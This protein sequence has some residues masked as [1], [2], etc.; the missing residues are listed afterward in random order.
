MSV[1]TMKHKKKVYPQ[2]E[3]NPVLCLFL[4]LA[5][6]S[7]ACPTEN[8]NKKNPIDDKENPVELPV[9]ALH[10]VV[11]DLNNNPLEG[12]RVSTGSWSATT[13]N[14][15][16]F[17]FETAGIVNNRAVIKFEKSG[18]FTIT[19]SGTK[20]DEIFIRAKLHRKGNSDISVQTTFDAK[21][22][23]ILKI[24]SPSMNNA[25]EVDLSAL[26]LARADGSDYEGD[27]TADMLYLDP[28]NENFAELMP[29]GDLAAT[30]TD[31]S[32][33]QLIS[34]GMTDVNFADEDGNP[35]QL[36]NGSPAKT[37]FPI[38]EGMEDNPP[39]TIPLWSFDEQQGIWVEEGVATLVPLTDG[40]YVYE[41][42]TTH[43]S[44]K[45]LDV[46]A[47]R[48]TLRGRVTDC[49]G[50]PA[51]YVSIKLG[52]V[53]VMAGRNGDYVAYVPD[54][55]SL[56]AT[57]SA[58]GG[59][60]SHNIPGQSGGSEYKQ[61]FSVPCGNG[62]PG[63]G[64]PGTLSDTDK[65]SVKYRLGHGSPETIILTFAENGQRTRWD[66]YNEEENTHTVIIGNQ[67]K[68]TCSVYDGYQW[69]TEAYNSM[70]SGCYGMSSALMAVVKSGRY[71]AVLKKSPQTVTIA[72]KSC[73]IYMFD[74]QDSCSHEITVWNG[75]MMSQESSCDGLSH[76]A[77]AATLNVPDWAFSQTLDTSWIE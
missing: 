37:T 41:G 20:Q 42:E 9:P 49:K 25:M 57:V 52:Q 69:T 71:T 67:S 17:R 74:D 13:G 27:V 15:G 7:M 10:G 29:G 16:K 19:R 2:K 61:D 73:D 26:A 40:T 68:D 12:V 60:V 77:E 51:P 23:A 62:G 55:T 8:D 24:Q 47:E 36:K 31:G 4:A 1:E 56:T 63:E 76:A 54:N 11:S 30:R 3:R 66:S 22:A 35:L 59:S 14:D 53:T 18:Y 38:P 21:S 70:Y 45:N 39:D 64:E 72:G 33:A 58:N 65:G 46:P 5:F 34:Y 43:F 32:E 48:V 6:T 28:N 44:W 75:L 50:E